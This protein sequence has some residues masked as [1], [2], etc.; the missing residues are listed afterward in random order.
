M[1]DALPAVTGGCLCG[2]VRYEATP[3]HRDG[4]YCHCRMC[5]LA[6]GNTRAAYLN[7]RKDQLR[8]LHEP[9]YF[10]SS[11]IAQ[12]GFCP[13]C[14]TPLSFAFHDSEF[15]DL[16]I[17]TLDDPSAFKPTEHWSIESRL[18]RWHTDDGLPG[19]RLDANERINQRWRDAY[20]DA[21]PGLKTARGG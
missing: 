10:A 16:A 14:G 15:M 21:A 19:H 13:N 9:A 20:G 2:R 8:W 12:R 7:L 4:Y 17:G 18:A 5:Q 6:F 11:K 1:P 3:T